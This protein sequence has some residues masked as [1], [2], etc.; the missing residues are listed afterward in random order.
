MSAL[1]RFMRQ[2]D[3]ARLDTLVDR[4]LRQ[5]PEALVAVVMLLGFLVLACLPGWIEGAL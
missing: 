1:E 3:D 4:F 2:L 5:L